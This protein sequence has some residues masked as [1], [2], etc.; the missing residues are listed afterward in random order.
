[1]SIV[2]KL[3]VQARL[4]LVAANW[5][6][7]CSRFVAV[8]KVVNA[9]GTP[10]QTQS[11]SIITNL[12]SIIVL[13]L[14]VAQKSVCPS[15]TKKR[16]FTANQAKRSCHGELLVFFFGVFCHLAENWHVGHLR[17]RKNILS[18]SCRNWYL[19]YHSCWLQEVLFNILHISGSPQAEIYPYIGPYIATHLRVYFKGKWIV[20]LTATSN[21]SRILRLLNQTEFFPFF[22]RWSLFACVLRACFGRASPESFITFGWKRMVPEVAE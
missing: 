11:E 16:A 4:V 2:D 18:S 13:C 3:L 17:L 5:K 12:L 20:W 7:I 22:L 9:T 15:H 10:T 1:M 21:H 6:P 19:M 14:S 8:T